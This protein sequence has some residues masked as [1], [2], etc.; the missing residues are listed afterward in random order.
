MIT[1][2]EIENFYSI[3][4]P[5]ELDLTSGPK[6]PDEPGRLVQTHSHSKYRSPRVLAVFGP[7]AAGKS[8]VLRAI[9]FIGWFVQN[10]FQFQ[11]GQPL[12]FHKF[13]SKEKVGAP[14]RLSITFE[15]LEDPIQGENG[16]TCL[17]T[18]SIEIAGRTSNSDI[19]TR[20]ALY[21]Q[22]TGTI[23]P[24]RIFERDGEGNVKTGS[25]IGNSKDLQLVSGILRKDASLVSTLAQFSNPF[26]HAMV[27]SARSI[28]TNI[29][30]M[31]H[32]YDQ[33]FMQD[34][35]ASNPIL[36]DDLNRDI[37]RLDLGINEMTIVQ[38][39]GKNHALFLHRGLDLPVDMAME[40]NG[41]QQFVNIFPLI[42]RVL[43]TG[44]VAVI[45][46]LD[47]SIHPSIVPEIIRW[48]WDEERNPY[49]AQLWTSSHTVSLLEDLL[50]EEIILCE[51]DANGNT[52]AYRLSD[53]KG[54]R[55]DDNFAAKY[56]GGVYGA[57]PVIG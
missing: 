17:Y 1:K 31:R 19:I 42:H 34:Y 49:G 2:L 9:A 40:S 8:N 14:T 15:G 37:R 21:Y 25:L 41:T 22:P 30:M 36:L 24:R 47:T 52:D 55:R 28:Q 35:Y 54:L 20:E 48:F 7:N 26:A 29:L 16:K 44:G 5:I 12:P 6:V 27:E 11:S 13:N 43:Q 32:Q 50:K 45:D 10:S 46:E 56:M 33:R 53:I 18:Y 38:R 3:G 39:D 4:E 23:R 57:V 51:K